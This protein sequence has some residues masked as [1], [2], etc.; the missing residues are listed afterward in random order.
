MESWKWRR[1]GLNGWKSE[2]NDHKSL[3]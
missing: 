1:E 3:W 2:R